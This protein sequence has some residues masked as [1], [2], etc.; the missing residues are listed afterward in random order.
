[1]LSLCRSAGAHQ[2]IPVIRRRR[3]DLRLRKIQRSNI[4]VDTI[5]IVGELKNVGSF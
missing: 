2:T 4:N 1:M 3:V 5:K